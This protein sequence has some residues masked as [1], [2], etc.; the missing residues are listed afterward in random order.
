[1]RRQPPA[2]GTSSD[3]NHEPAPA[4]V[5]PSG[6]QT[7]V[8]QVAL[9]TSDD[10]LFRRP[11]PTGTG[12][13]RRAV[14]HAYAGW[15]RSDRPR[16]S[17]VTLQAPRRPADGEPP[18]ATKQGGPPTAIRGQLAEAGGAAVAAAQRQRRSG[19]MDN[20][21]GC[22]DSFRRVCAYPHPQNPPLLEKNLWAEPWC[23]EHD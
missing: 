8:W 17:Q 5:W 1:M 10:P 18:P 11:S 9:Q 4:T 14:P 16:A 15:Q 12:Q 23:S 3:L 7:S 13:H 21:P 19:M 6:K 20:R 22:S 2:L